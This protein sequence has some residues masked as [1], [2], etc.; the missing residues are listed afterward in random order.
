MNVASR[1]RTSKDDLERVMGKRIK[2]GTT[3]LWSNSHHGYKIFAKD[4]NV[5]LQT[6]NILR[7]QRVGGVYH[8]QHVNA[9]PNKL[10]EQIK[11]I[12]WGVSTKYLRQYMNWY[13]AKERIKIMSNKTVAFSEKI[14]TTRAIKKLLEIKP[15]YQQLVSELN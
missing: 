15:K 3:I 1:G 8:T 5:E 9:T 14:L 2:M 13:K 10:K 6:I 4:C 12:F 7:N 11:N